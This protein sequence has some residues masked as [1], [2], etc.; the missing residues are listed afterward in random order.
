MEN[1]FTRTA[2]VLHQDEHTIRKEIHDIIHITMHNPDETTK[3]ERDRLF[4]GNPEPTPEQFIAIISQEV[5]NRL[6]QQS[7]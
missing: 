4:Y 7:N 2:K 1:I 5:R 3:S 6:H